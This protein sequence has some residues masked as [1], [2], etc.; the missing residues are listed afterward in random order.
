MCV[1]VRVCMCA[2]KFFN[3]NSNNMMKMTRMII[4]I[5]IMGTHSTKYS[6]QKKLK[7]LEVNIDYTLNFVNKFKF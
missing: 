1:C 7:L 6:T 2:L 4:V 5:I 3:P